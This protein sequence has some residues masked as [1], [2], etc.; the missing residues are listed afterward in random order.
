VS[1][2][3][4]RSLRSGAALAL[5]AGLL[6][7]A[8][9]SRAEAPAGAPSAADLQRVHQSL[10][11]GAF[12]EAIAELELWSDRGV[13]EADLSFNRGV[14]YLGRAES[15]ARRRADLGQ[16]LAAFEEARH[17]DPQD[18]EATLII[19]RIRT[20]IA[21][22]RAKRDADRVVARPRLA[23][24]LL[25]LVGEN[26]WAGLGA[27]GSGVLSLG[28]GVWLWA[29]S[30]RARLAGGLAA[31]FGLLLGALGAG[32]A[33]AGMRLRA[34]TAPAVVVV[35][36]ARLQGADGLPLEVARGASTLGEASNR[37]PEGTLV[38]IGA[39][40]GSLIQIE[41]GDRDAWLNARDVRRLA[42]AP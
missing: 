11:Q 22:E 30:E 15:P 21:T 23:R 41:W 17:L 13:V 19:E 10:E 5:A 39:E 31:A 24:A 40:R 4:V 7:H 18:E 36:E 12:S 2:V 26:I 8:E 1:S 29:R 16:A 34:S 25:G 9:T 6:G 38:H 27:A 35:E 28:L 14:A 42:G 32:M 33:L 20:S 37:V 3:L